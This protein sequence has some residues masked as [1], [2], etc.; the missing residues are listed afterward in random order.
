[1][2]VKKKMKAKP[3]LIILIIIAIIA[4]LLGLTWTFLASPVNKNDSKK[5]EVISLPL[6][7]KDNSFLNGI[8][9]FILTLPFIIKYEIKK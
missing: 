1:M 3:L 6:V 4:L 5:I 7:L 8:I 9:C 2:T